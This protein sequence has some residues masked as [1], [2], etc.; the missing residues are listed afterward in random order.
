MAK[1]G[2]MVSHVVQDGSQTTT[3][4]HHHGHHI[5][6]LEKLLACYL[7]ICELY[8]PSPFTSCCWCTP[9]PISTQ[10]NN[11]T[12]IVPTQ[13][14]LLHPTTAHVPHFLHQAE[15]HQHKHMTWQSTFFPIQGGNGGCDRLMPTNNLICHHLHHHRRITKNKVGGINNT[16]FPPRPKN[17]SQ[18]QDEMIKEEE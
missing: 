12:S 14:P 13:N 16:I 6:S 4:V 9:T 11:K 10:N 8:W 5:F 1:Q 18:V 2:K 17:P 3:M 7:A 15:K